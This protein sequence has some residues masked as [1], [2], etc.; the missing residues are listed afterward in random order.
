MLVVHEIFTSIQ[1]ESS[2]AGLPCTFVRLAGCNLRCAWCDTPEALS[3]GKQMP[4]SEVLRLALAP[5]TPVVEVTG[6]EPLLQQAVLPLLTALCD[7]DRIVMLETSGERDISGVDARVK[8]IMD[9]KAPSSGESE[10]NRWANLGLLTRRDEVKI[11]LRDRADYEWAS[12]VL[13]RERP[14]ERAGHVLLGCVQGE[15]D[16]SDLAAWILADQ[17]PV[18]IQIQL[19]KVIWGADAR[20]V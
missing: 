19:H 20:G 12:E 3:V 14:H 7:A 8:R 5:G 2:L 6:G 16:P 11:V 13:R 18:R 1:G 17:L 10:R 15:L 4:R 9:L